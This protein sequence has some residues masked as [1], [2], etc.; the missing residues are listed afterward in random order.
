MIRC[1]STRLAISTPLRCSSSYFPCPPPPT[2]GN[3]L[4]PRPAQPLIRRCTMPSALEFKTEVLASLFR[5]TLICGRVVHV[6]YEE[7]LRDKFARS[8]MNHQA[9]TPDPKQITNS[10]LAASALRY[11]RSQWLPVGV[12]SALLVVPCYW[13]RRIEAGDLASHTYNAWLAQLIGQGQA[14]GLYIVRQ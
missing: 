6:C 2:R 10:P 14:P 5:L 3:S 7:E 12:I 9:P 11:M 8:N 4:A 1:L 13:H